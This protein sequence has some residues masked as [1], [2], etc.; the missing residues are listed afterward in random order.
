MLLL[1]FSI[2]GDPALFFSDS[3]TQTAAAQSE[4]RGWQWRSSAHT[5]RVGE[6]RRWPLPEGQWEPKVSS[7]LLY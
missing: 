3:E 2:N 6:Q 5:A 7:P 1:V 4:W